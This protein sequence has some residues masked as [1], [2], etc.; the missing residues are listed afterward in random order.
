MVFRKLSKFLTSYT[1]NINL[2]TGKS[3]NV[4][5]AQDCPV[6]ARTGAARCAARNGGEQGR[7]LRRFGPIHLLPDGHQYRGHH[8][9][10]YIEIYRKDMFTVQ[11][12]LD[13]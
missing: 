1:D 2:L 5:A 7:R 12:I 10:K 4:S 8:Y 6:S 3:P 11:E 9:T 13:L